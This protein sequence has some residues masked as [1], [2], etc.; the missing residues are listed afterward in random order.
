[1]RQMEILDEGQLCSCFHEKLHIFSALS[2]Q[3]KKPLQEAVNVAKRQSSLEDPIRLHTG[4]FFGSL[5]HILGQTYS[6]SNSQG[7]RQ[8]QARLQN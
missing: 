2:V 3:V 1:M 8:R 6:C 7:L 5:Q 4:Q